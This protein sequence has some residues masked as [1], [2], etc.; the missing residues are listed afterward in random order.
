MK[1]SEFDF[2][3]PET[4]IAAF[5][6]DRRDGAR[7]M[8]LGRES[9]QTRHAS[10]SEIEGFLPPRCL[11]VVND[12]RVVPAR[13]YGHRQTGGH[14]ELLLLR[15]IL[16]E[17]SPHA[18]NAETWEAIGRNLG[19]VDPG[20]DLIFPS[21]LKVRFQSRHEGG[22][23][24]VLLLPPAG[25]T[26]SQLL[27]RIGDI[28]IPPYI[29]TARRR[30]DPVGS[31]VSD[32]VRE[33]ERA[34]DRERYQTVYAA[35][36]GSV[37]APTAGLHFTPELLDRLAAVGHTVARLTLHVGL[38][39]FR[40]VKTEDVASHR[41]DPEW[42][43]IS[44]ETA[45]RV[46]SARSEGRPIV[47]VGTTA[48]RALE[49]AARASEDFS[50]SP[51]TA[52]SRLFLTPGSPF[53]VVTD[54]ITNFHLPRSTLLMLVSAFAGRERVL[55]AYDEAIALGYRFYSYG[56]AMLIRGTQ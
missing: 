7:L 14:I 39:T 5:P 18:E 9:G 49:S 24:R 46:A 1:T 34:F 11:L 47:A 22:L 16:A 28:P 32:D 33:K 23:I 45:A 29:V 56:D 35:G 8:I 42:Y 19:R 51:G 43:T 13:L 10:F 44:E 12:S 36:P 6:L 3:L 40:P 17:D 31:V 48:V 4:N 38:G 25:Q 50:V 26:V 41:M 27:D 54:L 2:N 15:K 20:D 53:H 52:A 37:A 55:A 21:D 30:G